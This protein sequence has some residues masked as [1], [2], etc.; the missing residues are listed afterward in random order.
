MER[1]RKPHLVG[2]VAAILGYCKQDV[3]GH[4]RVE[5]T[6]ATRRWS[7]KRLC[8]DKQSYEDHTDYQPDSGIT[9]NEAMET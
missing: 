8:R 7:R 1:H 4:T 5:L 2:T 6:C 3:Q 9:T